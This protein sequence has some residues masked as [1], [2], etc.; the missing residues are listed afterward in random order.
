MQVNKVNIYFQGWLMDPKF[1]YV[2]YVWTSNTSQGNGAQVVVAGNLGYAF[3]DYATLSAGIGALPGV[4]TTE[5]NSPFWLGVDNRLIADEFF[6]PS[7]T[8]GIWS[9]GKV[10]DRVKYFLMV[11]NNLSQLGV[12]AAQLDNSFDTWSGGVVWAPTTGEFGN[13]G[14]LGDF[15]SHDNVATRLAAHYTRSDEDRQSQPGTEDPENSQI[16]ISDGNIVFKGE[17]FGPGIYVSKVRYQMASADVGL[18]YH[19]YALEAEV[20]R[21]WVDDFRGLGTENLP[22]DRLTDDGFQLQASGMVVPKSLQVYVS[23]SKIFGQYG[24]PSDSRIGANFYP[25]KNQVARWNVELIS[26]N[27]S[28]VGG[29]SLPYT[30]GGNGPVFHTNFEVNF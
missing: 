4:R 14:A 6:R 10:V 21:R 20:Y 11:G 25:W 28:P 24:D 18:K 16:R 22:F 9:Q 29:L 13:R 23:A 17:L 12:D 7:Y 27:D 8:T 26:L 19:G 5:G 2:T 15:E 30:V 3:N 1:R